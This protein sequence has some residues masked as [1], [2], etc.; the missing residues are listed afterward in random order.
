MGRITTISDWKKYKLNENKKP[1]L[2]N[3]DDL[4]YKEVSYI[5]KSGKKEIGEITAIR[6]ENRPNEK[7]QLFKV[8]NEWI[9]FTEIEEII[10]EI[11][12]EA[13]VMNVKNINKLIFDFEIAHEGEE[14]MSDND[15]ID[16]A[17]DI[18]ADAD[19]TDII[20]HKQIDSLASY[21]DGTWNGHK[22]G[23]SV[24]DIFKRL[25]PDYKNVEIADESL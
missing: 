18:I 1:N 13:F 14:D 2:T 19:M 22:I 10:E 23:A 3:T 16:L 9:K 25:E 20:D 11:K 8:N 15:F 5:S 21:L 7:I 6:S 4:L 24:E 12:N 17:K